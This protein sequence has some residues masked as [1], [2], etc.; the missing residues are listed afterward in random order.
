[1]A[2]ASFEDRLAGEYG[3][4]STKLRAAG[5]FVAQHPVDVATRS[6]RSVSASSGLA[7]ATFSRMA[8][9]LGFETY[10]DLRETLRTS[11]GRQVSSF[12]EKATRLQA[13]AIESGA[14]PFLQRQ[15]RACAANIEAMARTVDQAKLERVA[16]RLHAA[17]RVLMLGTLGSTGVVEYLSYLTSFF[18]RDWAIA[19]RMGASLGAGVTELGPKD[20]LIVITKPPFAKRAI[21]GAEVAAQRGAYVVV[22]TDTMS[23]P[24]LARADDSFVLPTDSPQFFSSY[25]ATLVLCETL[26]GM[27]VARSGQNAQDRINDV[28]ATNH[29]LGELWDA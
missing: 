1:M 5:D 2:A 12:S 23:C 14:P 6:L 3:A 28:S 27:L 20:A 15:S 24:A 22:I 29:R 7:P 25:A 16:D 13:E 21:L 26:V 19:G 17:D 10:E 18:T 4:L 9:A 11:V 8:R